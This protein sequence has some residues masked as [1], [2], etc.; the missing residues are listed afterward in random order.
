M[1]WLLPVGFV[2]AG[3]YGPM[4]FALTI[5]AL[6]TTLAYFPH[7]YWDLVALDSGPIAI[8]VVRNALLI[9]LLAACWPRPSIAGQPLGRVLRRG[10]SDPLAAD[11]RGLGALPDRL[12]EPRRRRETRELGR[13]GARPAHELPGPVRVGRCDPARVG[14]Q[15]LRGTG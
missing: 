11:H 1:V 7:S 10:S 5:A 6:L 15:A 4:A 3:R 13:Q 8:L 12:T 9:A 2:V 14:Q